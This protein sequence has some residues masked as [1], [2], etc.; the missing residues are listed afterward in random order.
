VV[1][2]VVLSSEEKDLLLEVLFEQRY[3]KEL[4]GCEIS[5]IERGEKQLVEV[6]MRML[7]QLFD[8]LDKA[9]L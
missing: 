7:N 5:D 1:K 6:R 3:A 2:D 9:G 4:V 8:R